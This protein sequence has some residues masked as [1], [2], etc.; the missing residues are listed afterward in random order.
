[1]HS[2]LDEA[3]SHWYSLLIQLQEGQAWLHKNLNYTPISA[4]AIDPFGHSPTMTNLLK[5]TG[6]KHM[7]VGRTHYIVKKHFAMYKHLEFN[8]N[9]LWGNVLFTS[10]AK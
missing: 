4:W 6:I 10:T 8:W 3:N 7:V 1:M 9:Q 5:M 2:Y